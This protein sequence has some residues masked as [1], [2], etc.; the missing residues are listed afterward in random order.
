MDCGRDVVSV[1]LE[2]DVLTVFFEHWA[3]SNSYTTFSLT[4]IE[5][6]ITVEQELTVIVLVV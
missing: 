1:A 5:A 2:S 3:A 4:T 6:G